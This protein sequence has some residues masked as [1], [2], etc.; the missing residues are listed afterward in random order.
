MPVH[1]DEINIV[2]HMD[3]LKRASMSDSNLTIKARRCWG[4]KSRLVAVLN[5]EETQEMKISIVQLMTEVRRIDGKL[6]LSLEG[7]MGQQIWDSAEEILSYT[8]IDLLI[9]IGVG[10]NFLKEI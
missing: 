8:Q 5:Q 7:P 1:N 2:S 6:M 3:R 4:T 9:I 10:A